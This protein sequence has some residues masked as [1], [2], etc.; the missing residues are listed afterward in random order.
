M[1]PAASAERLPDRRSFFNFRNTV[2]LLGIIV[3]T[4]GVVYFATAFSGIIS[5]WGR[6]LDFAL[7]TVIYVALGLHFAAMETDPELVHA[8]GWRWLRTTTAFYILGLVGG[9][10]TVIAFL[11]VDAVNRAIKLLVVVALGL[12][13]ILVAA[14]RWGRDRAPPGP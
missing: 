4:I 6:V 1:D 13:L 9:G 3:T 14:T 8:R 12:G 5:E 11:N 2:V 10:A 7:L